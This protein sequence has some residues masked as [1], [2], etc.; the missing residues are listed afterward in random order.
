MLRILTTTV[1]AVSLTASGGSFALADTKDVIGGIVA[2]MIATSIAESSA[3]TKRTTSTK[4]RRVRVTSSEETRQVQIALSHF[5]F[6]AGP[7]DGVMGKKTRN[8]IT[9]F[10]QF[11]GYQGTGQFTV[12][13]RE[14]L[15]DAYREALRAGASGSAETGYGTSARALL[16]EHRDRLYPS[17]ATTK[18]MVAEDSQSVQG[19]DDTVTTVTQAGDV[20]AKADV[21]SFDKLVVAYEDIQNQIALLKTL[22]EHQLSKDETPSKEIIAQAIDEAISKYEGIGEQLEETALRE[23]QTPIYPQNA[24]RTVT[25]LKASE[26]FPKIPYYIPGTTEIGEMWVVPTVTDDGYLKFM[27]NFMDPIAEYGRVRESVD[28]E[29]EELSAVAVALKKVERWSDK[30]QKS[31]IRRNFQKSALCFPES[32]CLEKKPGNSSTEV[33]FAIYEDGSTAAKVQRNKGSFASGFN[34]SIESS[35]LLVAYLEYMAEV[36]SREFNAGS[37]TND[38]LNEM[39]Q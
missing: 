39:F 28:L 23:Y 8:A 1:V 31:E 30:A 34:F 15:N 36:G 13:E 18:S 17:Q 29:S 20:A 38:E 12:F 21:G 19:T 2:G 9:E 6:D 11:L 10:Q 32:D 37:L 4:N 3:G 25:A 16:I 14:F 22:L 35:M 33:I 5:G 24:N 7:S 26:I 27:F